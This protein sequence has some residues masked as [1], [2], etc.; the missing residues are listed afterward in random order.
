MALTKGSKGSGEVGTSSGYTV[1]ILATAVGALVILVALLLLRR[2]QGTRHCLS[3]RLRLRSNRKAVRR[4]LQSSSDPFPSAAS[5]VMMVRMDQISSC[6]PTS[7]TESSL[8]P[9]GE[10]LSL[11]HETVVVHHFE[12]SPFVEH[13]EVQEKI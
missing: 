1:P 2:T 5:G 10:P 9:V 12:P 4:E 13:V 3:G 8:Y 6:T 7:T 11:A